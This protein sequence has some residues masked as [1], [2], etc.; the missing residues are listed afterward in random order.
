MFAQAP[1]NDLAGAVID[2]G[3]LALAFAAIDR[4]ACYHL[5]GVT[6]ESDSDHTV[7]LGWLAPA[8]AARCFPQLDA[9]LVAQFAL[10]HDMPEVYAGDTPTLR[11][12][13]AGRLAKAAREAVAVS[14]L[15]DEFGERL[16]WVPFMLT[17]YEAQRLPEARFVRALDKCLPKIV[18][19]LGGARGLIGE[20]V[21][22][23]ELREVFA[24]QA[25]DLAAY[26][27]D[28]P[29]LLELWAE[30][31]ERAI[32]LLAGTEGATVP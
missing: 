29:G 15:A 18:H 17:L 24:R 7:M 13:D 21:T 32:A 20:G 5:D 22:A 6:K 23:G 25:E 8:L 1:M 11:I 19:L 27:G 9:G 31:A 10:V 30:L 12:S 2:L 26:A 16:P 3:R 4:T 14:R 28:F